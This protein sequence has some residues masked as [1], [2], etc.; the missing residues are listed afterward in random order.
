MVQAA[1]EGGTAAAAARSKAAEKRARKKAAARAA[2]AGAAPSP[3]AA[4]PPERGQTGGA[5]VGA[6]D[7]VASDADALAAADAAAKLQRMSLADSAAVQKSPLTGSTSRH[8]GDSAAA[9]A[10]AVRRQQQPQAW[11]LC[12][13]TQV[14]SHLHVELEG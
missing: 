14:C 3:A 4:G 10:T 6:I 7:G 9:A 11:M 8:T 1:E 5:V 2:A 12:P 13:I